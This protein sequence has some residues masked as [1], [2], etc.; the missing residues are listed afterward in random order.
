MRRLFLLIFV[1]LAIIAL[2]WL[3]YR[4]LWLATVVLNDPQQVDRRAEF[5]NEQGQVV[6]AVRVNGEQRTGIPAGDYR[7]R[8]INTAIANQEQIAAHVP[9]KLNHGE[10]RVISAAWG[11][12]ELTPEEASPKVEVHDADKQILVPAFTLAAK[13]TLLLPPGVHHVHVSREGKAA[14]D[15]RV[16][17]PR[18]SL[19]FT[20][21][22]LE[23][24]DNSRAEDWRWL[25]SCKPAA[26][27]DG[28]GIIDLFHNRY[29]SNYH[30]GFLG[31]VSG[32]DGRLL[33]Q[34]D[35]PADGGVSAAPDLDGDGL[36]D[37][38]I[39]DT[40]AG[41]SQRFLGAFSGK[42]GKAIWSVSN[43][44]LP[45]GET[46]PVSLG[47]YLKECQDVSGAGQPIVIV[48][49]TVSREWNSQTGPGPAPTIRVM[50]SALDGKQGKL[51]WKIPLSDW[52]ELKVNR[53]EHGASWGGFDMGLLK[54]AYADLNGDGVR[55]IIFWG[56]NIHRGQDISETADVF[57][58]EAHSG[59]DG[60]RLWSRAKAPGAFVEAPTPP[61]SSHWAFHVPSCADL[62]GD[63]RAEVLLAE[64]RAPNVRLLALNGTD[65]KQKWLWESPPV[66][67]FGF[68]FGMHK[69]QPQ[70]VR[71]AN[72]VFVAAVVCDPAKAGEQAKLQL[73]LLDSRGTIQQR[74][75]LVKPL[76]LNA[77]YLPFWVHDVDG[78]GRDEI[79]VV[80]DGKLT[81]TRGGVEDIAW[82]WPIPG[83][84]GLILDFNA[85]KKSPG[86][87]VVRSGSQAFGLAG[88][89]GKLLWECQGAGKPI[90]TLAT[91]ENDIPRILFEITPPNNSEAVTL[92][93][94]AR[95]S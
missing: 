62:D 74:R 64:D 7:L 52:R 79:L 18:S 73:G 71:L 93:R 15:Y 44:L 24:A 11:A 55:D 49:Y 75:D 35:T 46:K 68:G 29:V 78:D 25:A 94:S 89:T 60:R 2:G 12:V 80:D 95:R 30:P 92:C 5:L 53:S 82:Q 69:T 26:D 54:P 63:G 4:N 43:E 56:K 51:L 48:A 88:D 67:E 1:C 3:G 36:P 81:V 34:R 58:L 31:I 87:L 28:D 8:I 9:I 83:G 10:R 65:A 86:T 66:D 6:H 57:S 16:L 37:V 19:A 32:R 39:I 77:G 76:Q 17:S 22:P 72:G 14:A 38:L 91:Q 42:T 45:E 33:W 21:P 61:D 85:G 20:L 59:R 90:A 41:K 84:R 40:V 50:M 47:F 23:A 13:R 70:A 27:V